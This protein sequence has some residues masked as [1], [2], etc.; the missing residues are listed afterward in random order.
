MPFPEIKNIP[1]FSVALNIPSRYPVITCITPATERVL[2]CTALC[3]PT[4][5]SPPGFSVKGIFQ[6]IIPEWVA[7]FYSRGSSQPASSALA[8]GFFTSNPHGKPLIME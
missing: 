1:V 2:S 5:Y 4:D 8:G 7:I 6:T 3:D